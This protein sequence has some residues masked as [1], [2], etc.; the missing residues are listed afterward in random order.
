MKNPKE[1]GE[2][3]LDAF[4]YHISYFLAAPGKTVTKLLA[5]HSGSLELLW[6]LGFRSPQKEKKLIT[7]ID[8]VISFCS[9]FEAERDNLPYEIDGLVIKINDFALQE[10]LGMTSHHPRWAIAYKFKARQATTILEN[11]EFQVGRTGA[12]TPVAKLKAV[13]VGGVMVSSISMH[14]EEDIKEK[15]LRLGDT[16]IIERAGDV[17]PQIVQSIASLRKGTEKIISFPTHCPVCN[18]LLEKE[19]T[20]AVWRCNS[21]LC[22]A[23]IIEKII[24]FVSKDAMDIKSF[25]EANIRKFYE[26][27]ILKT[28]PDLYT[29]EL[30][31][32]SGLEGFGKKSIDN[33][34]A[35]IEVSKAQPL[36]RFIYAL[37]IR[38]VGE[39][40]AKT[41][42]AQVHHILDLKNYSEEQLQAF[43]DVG[44]KVAKS[45]FEFFQEAKNIQLIQSLE[46]LGLNMIQT[47][48]KAVDGN[49]TGL[50]FLFTGTL[51]QL[52]R[53]DAEAMVEAA[54]GHILSGVSS[55]LN[56]LVVGDDAGSK[57][58][59]AKKIATIKIITEADFV[60]LIK[61]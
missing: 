52:K 11:V 45:I 48:T 10:K 61:N 32:V 27:G 23:Q 29:L 14:N 54:G 40:T 34:K 58:E 8:K 57:L 15:D 37:G 1:V 31:K 35:A 22:T 51:T 56:Y 26:L 41:I 38:F 42:A 49:L 24:H 59:K 4:I 6:N 50:N 28:I 13:A 19:E 17:I 53:S 60:E 44:V 36:Y 9:T 46:A 21:P 12:V 30:E 7:G 3:N 5:T 16:V 47:N 39:T 20:E 55:K 43:E 2:R 25:G 18:A 33:L